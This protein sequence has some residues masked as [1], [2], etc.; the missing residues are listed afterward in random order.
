MLGRAW[1]QECRARG[2]PATGVD[3][4]VLD[5]TRAETI[6]EVV[7]PHWTHVINCAAWTDV[8]GAET[9]EEAAT[10]INARGVGY[11]AERCK[12]VGSVLVHYSTD[13]VFD[14]QATSPYRVDHQRR[15]VGAYGRSKARGEEVLEACAGRYLLMR[16]SWL[17]A[18]WGKNFVGTI[19]ALAARQ[20]TLKVVADQRGRPTSAEHL[21]RSTL[22]LLRRGALGTFH[23]TDGGE[24]TWH[25][26]ASQIVRLTG[27]AC[28][29]VPCTTAEYP[30]PAKRPAYSVL[31][32]SR[33]EDLIGS[34]PDWTVNLGAV[35]PRLE[36]AAAPAHAAR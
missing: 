6:R 3:Q 25:E 5:L 4:P 7:E 30:R 23:V 33:A 13:Y 12:Q 19:A 31:D 16:T 32:L 24:C 8:D 2:V 10:A 28:E 18:P 1:L 36:T 21:A 34:M 17:Y 11:L 14:G 20:P 29:V 35:V 26:F 22:A 9:Q 15:P 27:A